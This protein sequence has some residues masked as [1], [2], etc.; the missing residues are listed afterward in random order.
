MAIASWRADQKRGRSWLDSVRSVEGYQG[1]IEVVHCLADE[2]VL[3]IV[4]LSLRVEVRA[5]MHLPLPVGIACLLVKQGEDS[6]QLLMV[7]TQFAT[8][9]R[10]GLPA[11]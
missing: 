8:P 6:E 5:T 7:C 9:F 11:F 2:E 1:F 3:A 10:Q 4:A